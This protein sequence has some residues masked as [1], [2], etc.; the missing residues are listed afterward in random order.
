MI[1]ARQYPDET[2]RTS[3]GCVYKIDCEV[4]GTNYS[5]E[6]RSGA[7]YALARVLVAAGV[8]DQPMTVVTTGLAGEA[9][10][11]SIHRMAGYTISESA[12]KPAA[13]TRYVAYPGASGVGGQAD[14]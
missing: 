12:S 10:Y 14:E 8:P 5:I 6:S 7:P 1:L 11:R 3:R 13:L 9:Q 2:R 4:D